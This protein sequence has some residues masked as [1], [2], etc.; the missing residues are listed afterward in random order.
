M[1]SKAIPVIPNIPNIPLIPA[2]PAIPNSP[3]IPRA[4][5][6]LNKKEY[7]SI[8]LHCLRNGSFSSHKDAIKRV[9]AKQGAR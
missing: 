2:I 5:I 8:V 1:V 3:V 9:K 7:L 4:A 6:V